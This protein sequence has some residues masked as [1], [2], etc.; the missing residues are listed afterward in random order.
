MDDKKPATASSKKTAGTKSTRAAKG[1]KWASAPKTGGKQPEGNKAGDKR[2][3]GGKGKPD[4][5]RNLKDFV[6]AH[7][8]GWSHDE[9]DGLLG[10]LRDKGH[11]VSDSETIGIELERER[12][13]QRLQGIPGLGPRRVDALVG[14]FDT[15]WSLQ[16]ASAEEIVQ[17]PSIPRNVAERVRQEL[18]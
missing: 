1:G 10:S 14:R 16:Q 3:T 6:S 11:D 18:R 15:L 7:P 4:L 17:L 12:L 5:G 8:E 2:A 9:W 13:R